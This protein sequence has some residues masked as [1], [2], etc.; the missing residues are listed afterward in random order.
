MATAPA[1]ASESYDEL[2]ERRIGAVRAGRPPARWRRR[3]RAPGRASSSAAASCASSWSSSA[4]S[5]WSSG[6]IGASSRKGR[7]SVVWR[8]RSRQRWRVG[9]MLPW[10]RSRSSPTS[11][12]RQRRVGGEQEQQLAAS[13]RQA[14]QAGVERRVEL[15]LEEATR[16][17]G[18]GRRQV[19]VVEVDGHVPAAGPQQGVHLVARRGG[20]PAGEL[21]RLPDGV[22]AL[23]EA[24]EGAGEGVL[25]VL[26]GEVEARDGSPRHPLEAGDELVPGGRVA[27][28][29]RASEG[30]EAV[31]ERRTVHSGD[32]TTAPA[33]AGDRGGGHGHHLPQ[34]PSGP[35][36]YIEDSAYLIGTG[37]LCGCVDPQPGA[38]PSDE[39]HPWHS[40]L[41]IASARSPRRRRSTRLVRPVGHR[42]RRST[43]MA[44][45]CGSR[46]WCRHPPPPAPP[47]ADPPPGLQTR[48]PVGGAGGPSPTRGRGGTEGR[49]ADRPFVIRAGRDRR[50]RGSSPSHARRPTAPASSSRLA[51]YLSDTVELLD[52]AGR[53]LDRLGPDVGVLG[54]RPGGAA[55]GATIDPDDLPRL[56]AFRAAALAS[57]PGWRGELAYR[58]RTAEG[59]LHLRRRRGQ[60]DRRSGAAGARRHDAVA[61]DRAPRAEHGRGPDRCHLRWIARRGRPDGA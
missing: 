15:A 38:L 46:W 22:E 36:G 1:S 27:V 14:G 20:H 35:F 48:R 42:S 21:G 37:R 25:A 12:V 41:P 10:G 16:R 13:A 26:L 24:E 57:A 34:S 33:R 50:G 61:G 58:V 28:Q 23:V 32:C 51:S 59:V 7:S 9:P 47:H 19:L 5:R 29:R 60:P 52:G 17:L 44:S 18:V 40:S 53:V 30:V 6:L 54:Q 11:V 43:G 3:R 31:V 55:S 2:G 49:T 39:D 45:T 4:R 8:S 56:L